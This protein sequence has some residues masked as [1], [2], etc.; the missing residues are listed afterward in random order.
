MVCLDLGEFSDDG[1]VVHVHAAETSESLG[2]LFVAVLLDQETGGFGKDQHA[3]DEDDSPGELDGNGD[4]VA[5]G[6]IT[7]LSSIVDDGGEEETNCD[8][9]L[10]GA[11]DCATNPFGCSLGLVE[12]DCGGEETDT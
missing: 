1:G 12:G 11:D 8:S 2:S 10:V 6:V 4:S 3:N 9:E 7:V 5:A